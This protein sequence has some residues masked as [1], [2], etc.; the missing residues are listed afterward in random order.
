MTKYTKQNL[1]AAIRAEDYREG[2]VIS[3]LATIVK[4]SDVRDSYNAGQ[5][6]TVGEF[7]DNSGEF[8]VYIN[9]MS[10]SL[11]IDAYGDYNGEIDGDELIGKNV[12]ITVICNDI[13][14]NKK[15][16]EIKPYVALSV[17]E[18]AAQ[19]KLEQEQAS[20]PARAG[21]SANGAVKPPASKQPATPAAGAR[22]ARK[23]AS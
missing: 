13:T 3:E 9:K 14:R 20:K 10:M 12:T 2:D 23:P 17:A 15:A 16:F 6:K 8:S 22:T 7:A 18:L 4:V 19:Q 5:F 11:L 1:T 21:N